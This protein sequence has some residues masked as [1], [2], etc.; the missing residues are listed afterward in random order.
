VIAAIVP[1][2][3][4]AHGKSR[5]A[6]TLGRDGAARLA[7][8]MLEDVVAALCAVRA[9]DVVAVVTP[10]RT[11]AEA[12]ERAGARALL[13]DDPGLNA[14]VDRA[15]RELGADVTLVVLGDVAGAES[16]DLA[17]LL[18]TLA[19]LPAPAAVLAPARDGGSAALARKPHGA[20]ASRFGPASAQ[21][22]RDAARGAGVAFAERALPSLAL[23]LDEEGDLRAF[24]ATASGGA[25]TRAALHAL[26]V[27]AKA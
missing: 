22:H 10:D 6:A 12:A 25:R 18:E 24:L 3:E 27:E 5:L 1:V 13:G 4:L 20:I 17:A 19:A 14:S 21:A 23:D 26:G 11:V 15:A 8:A 9:V 16:E 2:K 7:Q